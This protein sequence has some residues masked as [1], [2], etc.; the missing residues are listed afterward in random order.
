VLQRQLAQPC[1]SQVQRHDACS[2]D[3][4]M[5]CHL[6][7][8]IKQLRYAVVL[9]AAALSFSACA[10]FSIVMCWRFAHC[11][12]GSSAATARCW[13]CCSASWR[14]LATAKCGGSWRQWWLLSA[15]QCLTKCCT[16]LSAADSAELSRDD[17][18]ELCDGSAGELG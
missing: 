11:P 2:S 16:E 18:V 3:V 6:F 15:P 17:A 13:L 4:G 10:L 8:C 9:A 12:A 14:S 1:Y 7:A 5:L